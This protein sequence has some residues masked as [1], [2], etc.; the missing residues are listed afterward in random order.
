[1]SKSLG[2]VLGVTKSGSH[3]MANKGITSDKSCCLL[4]FTVD[5]VVPELTLMLK[6]QV[7]GSGGNL[8]TFGELSL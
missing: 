8:C 5:V 6:N 3:S 4:M 2:R 1:M 7:G